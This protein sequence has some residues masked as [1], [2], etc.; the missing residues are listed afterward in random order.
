VAGNCIDESETVHT[1]PHCI[2]IP[3]TIPELRR[4]EAVGGV[5]SV[6]RK[7]EVRLNFMATTLTATDRN[8]TGSASNARSID[9]PAS[10]CSLPQQVG[11]CV[12]GRRSTAGPFGA[13]L[14]ALCFAARLSGGLNR[15]RL[16]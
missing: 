15:G 5:Q 7:L 12:G 13:S 1:T 11:R 6:G 9:G 8:G 2:C 16:F 3:D 4:L 10:C 14:A